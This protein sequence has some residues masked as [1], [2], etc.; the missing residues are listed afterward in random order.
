MFW[1]FTDLVILFFS[2]F[3]FSHFSLLTWPIF[4]WLVQY[5]GYIFLLF[6]L[7]YYYYYCYYYYF[8][9]CEFFATVLTVAF[10]RSQSDSKSPQFFMTLLS[11]LANLNGAVVWVVT[12]LPL[13]SSST[14]FFFRPLRTVSS[15]RTLIGTVVTFM[16]H[17]FLTLE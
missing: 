13:F 15:V 7:D 2:L 17:V 16:F 14:I 3:H 12:I 6:V 11:V 4:Q 5:S 10:C 8:T 9:I 1:C